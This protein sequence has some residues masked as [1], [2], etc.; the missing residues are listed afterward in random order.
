M[1][2]GAKTETAWLVSDAYNRGRLMGIIRSRYWLTLRKKGNRNV[3]TC[4]NLQERP[5]RRCGLPGRQLER[6]GDGCT[7]KFRA[8]FQCGVVRI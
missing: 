1:R 3:H 4:R 5:S 8:E 6:S 2:E 7:T